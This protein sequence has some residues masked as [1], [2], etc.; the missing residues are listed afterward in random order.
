MFQCLTTNKTFETLRFMP[1]STQ[2]TSVQAAIA[3]NYDSL[4]EALKAAADFIVNNGF[5]VATRSLR[6]IATESELSPSSFSRLARAI[7]FE[8]YEQLR[9]QARDELA[10]SANQF[11]IKAKQLHQDAKRPFLPRQVNACVTNIQA[12]LN[13][14]KEEELE[15]AVDTLATASKVTLIG[16]LSSASF[17]DYFSYL[18]SW[19]DDRWSVAGRNGL[20]LASSLTRLTKND[21]V[22]VISKAPYAKRAVLATRMA[23]ERGATIIVL[24]DS[25]TFPAIKHA[26]HVFIHKTESP[27]FFVSYAATLVLIETLTGMLLARAGKQAITDIESLV[28]QNQLLDEI[29]L[30][31]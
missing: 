17:T 25:H 1:S 23:A 8:D 28:A 9:D 7:G 30:V 31:S 19:F 24:T 27:Q 15:A 22:I 20:T 6:S 11:T 4:S 14:I 10:N 21:V 13:D 2:T 18:T 16:S 3:E 29:S 12:L 26:K 5:E